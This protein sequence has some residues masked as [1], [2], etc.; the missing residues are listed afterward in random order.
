MTP[1]AL[2]PSAWMEWAYKYGFT[3]FFAVAA[4]GLGTWFVITLS[5]TSTTNSTRLTQIEQN[6]QLIAAQAGKTDIRLEQMQKSLDRLE[7][8]HQQQGGAR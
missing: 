2:L 8:V 7:Q 4:V 6:I 5:N 1:P 3:L